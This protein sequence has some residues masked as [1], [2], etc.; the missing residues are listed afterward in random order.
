V[1]RAKLAIETGAL[2]HEQMETAL[3]SALD[4]LPKAKRVLIIPPDFTRYHSRA[5]LLTE[6]AWRYYGSS[7]ADILPALGTHFA[8]TD[9]EISTMY[10]QTPRNLFRVHNWRKDVVTLGEVP[11]E[12]IGELTGGR[13]MIP[14]P[15]QV[16]RMLVE[17]KYDRILSIGQV[18]PHE[19]IGMANYNKNIFVGTGGSEGINKS[20]FISAVLG[21]ENILGR[22]DNPVRAILNYA[23]DHFAQALPITYVQTVIGMD[24][25]GKPEPR[26]IFVGDDSECFYRASE[27]SQRANIFLV[28]RQPKK[29]VA[30]M[31]PG[32]FKSTWLANKAVYRSR[33]AIADGGE[34]VV[35][36]PGLREFGEDPG[37]DALIRRY[38]YC[39]TDAVLRL[40]EQNDDLKQMLGAAAH[41][42]HGSSEGRFSVTYAPGAISEGEIRA[43]GYG[44]LDL[45]TAL[46][47]YAPDSLKPGFNTLPDGEE[48]YFVPNPALGLWAF[49]ANFPESASR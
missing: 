49:R 13:L 20:H 38:G 31:D 46:K 21:I 25:E 48:V 6:M 41:L 4:S 3:F 8:M 2:T 36:A 42:I 14:W 44:Y 32:E 17:G 29:I 7:L 18:V 26:G 47:R 22:A 15:A 28:E 23:S 1:I 39:G 5:G 16:N 43:A 34:L 19:V 37:I 45:Q 33:L 30:W 35:I 27:L 12:F 9:E 10:G 11:A 40:V 24:A